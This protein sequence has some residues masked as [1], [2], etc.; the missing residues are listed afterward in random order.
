MAFV[1]IEPLDQIMAQYGADLKKLGSRAKTHRVIARAANY[2]GRKVFTVVKRTLARQTSIKYGAINK[3]MRFFPAKTKGDAIETVIFGS[4]KHFSLR[5]FGPRQ[6]KPGTRAKVWGKNKMHRGAFM[7]PRPGAVSAKL[8]GHVWKRDTAKRYPI[9]RVWGPS[10]PVEMVKD[11]T[12]EAFY[13]SAPQII[14]R[15]SKEIAAVMRGF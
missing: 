1:R 3:N 7:G 12:L 2:E 6:L 11:A 15:V 8:G 9:S 10:I 14:A 4:G 13:A 5:D